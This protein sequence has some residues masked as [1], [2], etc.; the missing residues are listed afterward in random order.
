MNINVGR[1]YYLF[2]LIETWNYNVC[3]F[4]PMGCLLTSIEVTIF[5]KY[6]DSLVNENECPNEF[7]QGFKNKIVKG[8]CNNGMGG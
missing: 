7:M 5:F 3:F 6:G 8:K 4:C 2:A 1:S